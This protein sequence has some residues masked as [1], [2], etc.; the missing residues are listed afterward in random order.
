M[1]VHKARLFLIV[2]LLPVWGAT[3]ADGL[4]FHVRIDRHV[5]AGQVGPLAGQASDGEFIRRLHLDLTG[6]IPSSAEARD[7]IDDTSAT[8]RRAAI[9][10]LLASP[11]YARHMA[12]VFDVMLMERRADKYVKTP[13]W[14]GYLR[15]A[16]A[17][18][19]PWDA[20]AGEIIGT[21]GNRTG[22]PHAAA[23]FILDREAEP[24]LVTRDLARKFFG[25]D[26]QCAQCH[27][28][29]NIDD[30]YQRDYFGIYAFVSR[31]FVFRPDAQK[32]AVLAERA[33]GEAKFKSVFTEI[34]GGMRPR[35]PG[36]FEITEPV[37]SLGDEWQ[38]A[39]NPKNKNLRGIPKYSRRAQ[40]AK[41]AAASPY[42]GRNIANR[43]WGHMMGRALVEPR[44]GLHTG[45]PSAHPELLGLLADEFA[46]HNYD[47]RVFLRELALSQTYQ[48]QFD[49]PAQ[50]KPT[51]LIP[52]LETEQKKLNAGTEIAQ[53]AFDKAYEALA[54]A[55]G[56]RYAAQGVLDKTLNPVSTAKKSSD[57]A[58]KALAA[59][60]KKLTDKQA[61]HKKVAALAAQAKAVADEFKD[62]KELADPAAKL[63]AKVDKLAAEVAAAQKDTITK[64]ATAKTAAEKLDAAQTISDASRA[65]WAVID[66]Q[67]Q[68]LDRAWQA[69][70]RGRERAMHLEAR[71]IRRLEDAQAMVELARSQNVQVAAI[72]KVNDAAKQLAAAKAEEEP[73]SIVLAQL[74][75]PRV[76]AQKEHAASAQVLAASQK[77][78][79]E[80]QAHAKT[81]AAA[82]VNAISSAK[83]AAE[84]AALV[85]QPFLA[86]VT[87]LQAPVTNAV[88]RSRDAIATLQ[89]L[90][91]LVDRDVVRA[92]QEVNGRVATEQSAQG[93]L[94]SATRAVAV[95]EA[96][97]AEAQKRT[98]KL[99]A[100]LVDVQAIANEAGAAVAAATETLGRRWA[101]NF[102]VG[103]FAH[104][105]PEQLCWSMLRASGQVATQRAAALADF[106]K[107][108]P[109]KEGAKE[110]PARGLVR[111]T[112]VEKFIYDKLKGNTAIFIKLFGGAAG[113]VQ[114][115]F[116]ATADQALYFANGGTVRSWTGTLA[117]RL[118]QLTDPKMLAEE[119]YL[120]ILTRRP[121]SAEVAAVAQ[122][123]TAQNKN[124][125]DAIR[126]MAWGLMTSTEFRFRH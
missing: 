88:A 7:F 43:L 1:N 68:S 115:D 106:D 49:L 97:L 23:K 21:D 56:K 58:G 107:K 46:A 41:H 76:A 83:L 40:L 24:N 8:K 52:T 50:I 2:T 123:L 34:S 57:A 71:A 65:N 74:Q 102:G 79:S 84:A 121:T 53:A 91:K 31:S 82:V 104:L 64:T 59:A 103:G 81:A 119:L 22:I 99:A 86:T 42:F 111:A 19:K 12:T 89:A 35:V 70:A 126:E 92:Q 100:E 38:V 48:R 67:V 69:A 113:E 95:A 90:Q 37:F 27:D 61:A 18:N 36:D 114:T 94:D 32:P 55:R 96:K 25:M 124:R 10:A 4:P 15:D 98:G 112:H 6:R 60:Q 109:L 93:K 11:E 108:N 13:A 116:Y 62:D 33:T 110:D 29:P 16:F 9:D 105:T 17:A 5:A 117:G 28:H 85:T 120:S 45:N 80:K 66:K 87:E 75:F 78:L 72:A 39:P 54:V 118:N 44:D 101:N 51:A 26:L 122:H 63:K 73:L 77:T 125:S 47:V 3:A 14:R 20:M 30:Y